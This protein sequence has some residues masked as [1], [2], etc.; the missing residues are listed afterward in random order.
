MEYTDVTTKLV[1]KSL[2]LYRV[3]AVLRMKDLMAL[4]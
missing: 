2:H 3:L 1:E 4:V